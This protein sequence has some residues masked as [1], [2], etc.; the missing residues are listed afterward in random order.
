MESDY[1]IT[2]EHTWIV[3]NIKKIYYPPDAK[4]Q[5]N[6]IIVPKDQ[7]LWAWKNKVGAQKK[8]ELIDS[9]IMGYPIPTCIL[10]CVRK[11]P[12]ISTNLYQ[13]YD[14]RHRIETIQLFANGKFKWKGKKYS[15]LSPEHKERF[16]NRGLP[17]TV[18]DNASNDQL[19]K[20]FIRLNKGVP[21][22]DSD[23]FWANRHKELVLAVQCEVYT[24]DRLS[25]ALGGVDLSTRSDLANWVG[26]VRGLNTDNAGNISTSYI[27][28]C[29]GSGLDKAVDRTKVKLGLDAFTTLLE[30]ANAKF[31]CID[32]D[33]R[34]FKKV[35]KLAAFFIADWAPSTDQP[36]TIDKWVEIIGKLRGTDKEEMTK[37]LS[38]T[39]AQNLTAEKIAKVLK[40]V[41][42]YVERGV[43]TA[44]LASDED[45]EDE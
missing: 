22:K 11:G 27:R 3:S 23:L 1:I 39:G 29:E 2:T 18:V 34:C 33:K 43:R 17:I 21:L 32:R 4:D 5:E 42:D 7:R 16:N 20:I 25:V 24:H 12:N 35:G 8:E 37:A 45:E 40:Q 41:N 14:G 31:D 13:V 28:A 30:K 15:E 19:A 10:N 6:G 38:T 26:L 9:I 44:E 36:A